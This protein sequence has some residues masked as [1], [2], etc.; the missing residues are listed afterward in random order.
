MFNRG[1]FRGH[2]WEA[3]LMAHEYRGTMDIR[4]NLQSL[5]AKVAS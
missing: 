1:D 3:D 2:E 5:F 4:D